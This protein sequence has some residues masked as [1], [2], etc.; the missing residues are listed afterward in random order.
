M[1]EA[2]EASGTLEVV[3]LR[4]ADFA[5]AQMRLKNRI[6]SAMLYPLIMIIV[7]SALISLIFILVIGYYSGYY[8]Q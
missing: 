4:L 5:E 2:G 8:Y 7:G 6:Q 1:V 3:L